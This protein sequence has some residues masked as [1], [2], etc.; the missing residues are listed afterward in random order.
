MA[1]E[2]KSIR[3]NFHR[4]SGQSKDGTRARDGRRAENAIS[5]GEKIHLNGT[6][7]LSDGHEMQGADDANFEATYDR[8]WDEIPKVNDGY[9]FT[10]WS[11]DGEAMGGPIDLGSYGDNFGCTP[12]LKANKR[13][14]DKRDHTLS[15]YQVYAEGTL[16]EVRS[17]TITVT[18]S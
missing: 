11:W 3:L 12:S 15:F 17:E 10:R 2:I 6:P 16:Q 7:V 18:I 13:D 4:G 5:W 8:A 9:I 1:R 14:E